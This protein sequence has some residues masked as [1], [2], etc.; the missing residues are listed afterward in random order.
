MRASLIDLAG[1]HKYKRGVLY[2]I[3]R[4]T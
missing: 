1:E 3:R 2:C 4:C